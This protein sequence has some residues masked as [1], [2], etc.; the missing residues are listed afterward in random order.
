MLLRYCTTFPFPHTFLRHPKLSYGLP[1]TKIQSLHQH[2]TP[3]FRNS[4]NCWRVL[5]LHKQSRQN[6]INTMLSDQ[7]N[8]WHKK[9]SGY[10]W[11]HWP[12]KRHWISRVCGEK[13]AITYFRKKGIRSEFRRKST[14]AMNW[15]CGY[16][17]S[18]MDILIYHFIHYDKKI[19]I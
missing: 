17:V 13:R 3:K 10:G 6:Y 9:D 11:D 18:L 7:F 15:N 4:C 16:I 19:W 1:L 2:Y 12:P 14:T 5:S 8:N